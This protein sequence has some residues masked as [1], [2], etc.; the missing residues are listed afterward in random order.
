VISALVSTV[1]LTVISA[2][3][4][5]VISAL[6][7]TVICSDD[8]LIALRAIRAGQARPLR[9]AVEAKRSRAWFRAGVRGGVEVGPGRRGRACPARAAQSAAGF[10]G[11]SP[12]V[13]AVIRR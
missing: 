8:G 2:L 3:V 4:S 13:S 12:L 1:V 6:V 9:N 5:T 10:D 11:D 7:S